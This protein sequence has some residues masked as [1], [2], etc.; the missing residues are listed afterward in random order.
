M[1]KG[2]TISKYFK[3]YKYVAAALF[4]IIV[5]NLV[6]FFFNIS[7]KKNISE[8]LD[9]PPTYETIS[10]S[11]KDTSTTLT[12]PNAIGQ[13]YVYTDTNKN[14]RNTITMNTD[15]S[16]IKLLFDSQKPTVII[17]QPANVPPPNTHKA[18][19]FPKSFEI[20]CTFVNTSKTYNLISQDIST[21]KPPN[22]VISYITTSVPYTSGNVV[23]GNTNLSKSG[24]F[25]NIVSAM[26]IGKELMGSSNDVIGNASLTKQNKLN[27]SFNDSTGIDGILLNYN[28]PL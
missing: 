22:S 23:S 3:Y 5:V 19:M 28:A 1:L 2:K 4:L 16:N 11:L 21:N 13:F 17:I 12:D 8:G 25:M 26:K 18:N 15:A 14:I 24:N 20:D 9:Q 10:I 6:I 7:Q 27:I